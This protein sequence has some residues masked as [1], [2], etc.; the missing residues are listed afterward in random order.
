MT[1]KRG[2]VVFDL[3]GTLFH[4]AD[5]TLPAT[6]RAFREMG[7]PQP[8]RQEVLSFIGQSADA[9]HAWVRTCCPADLVPDLVASVDRYE[10]ELVANGATLF[11]GVREVLAEVRTF[12]DHMAICTNGYPGYVEQVIAAHQ[13]RGYFDVIRYRYA[14]DDTKISMVRELLD[15]LNGRPV[16]VVGDRHYD[17]EAAHQNGAIAIAASYGYGS[18]AELAPAE[19]A[20][21]SP[22]ELSG[23]IRSLLWNHHGAVG[24]T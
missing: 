17:V 16:V 1:E 21:S 5:A 9:F 8:D 23:L 7:L 18:A 11:P 12:V 10:L 14:D 20:V 6:M 13:L 19:F 15:R 22:S 2:L 3:D 4:S 24:S